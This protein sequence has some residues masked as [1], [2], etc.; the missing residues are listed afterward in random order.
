MCSQKLILQATPIILLLSFFSISGSSTSGQ[1]E[2]TWSTTPNSTDWFDPL[3]WDNGAPNAAG[4]TANVSGAANTVTLDLNTQATLGHLNFLGTGSTKLL[5]TGPLLFDNPGALPASIRTVAA[6]PE[7]LDVEISAP[8]LIAHGEHLLLDLVTRKNLE[9]SGSIDSVDG[10]ITK[11]GAGSLTLSGDNST[12]RGSLTVDAGELVI[13]D[14]NA[15]A[16]SRDVLI[17]PDSRL[18]FVPQDATGQRDADYVIPSVSIDGGIL[19]TKLTTFDARDEVRGNIAATKIDTN[20]ELISDSSIQLTSFDI[21][22][23]DGTISG[24]GGLRFEKR[25][26]PG[27]IGGSSSFPLLSINGSTSY[28]GETVIGPDMRVVF[29]Q[30]AAL[31]DASSGTLVD[32]GTLELHAGG[33][34]EQIEIRRGRLALIEA[35]DP[36]GHKIFLDQGQLFGGDNDGLAATLNT[37]VN[38]SGGAALGTSSGGDNLVLAEGISGT[39]SVFSLNQVEIAGELSA[40]GHFIATNRGPARL[41]GKLSQAGDVFVSDTQLILSG[42]LESPRG[43]F[44]LNPDFTVASVVAEYSNTLE[45][46]VIDPRSA[47]RVG[48][49]EEFRLAVE[50]G[51]ALEIT[52]ELHFFGGTLNGAIT[53]QSVLTKKDRTPGVLE[54]IRGSEFTRVDVEAGQLSVRGDA[55][56]S[57]PEIHLGT[58]DTSRLVVDDAGTYRGDIFLNN[59][60]SNT[61]QAALVVSGNTIL[62]GNIYLGDRGS[63]LSTILSSGEVAE[64]TGVVHGGDFAVLGRQEIRLRSGNH[65]FSGK[66]HVNAESFTL[67]DGGVLNSTSAIVGA[68]RIGLGGGRAGLILDNGGESSHGDR[69]PDLTPVHLEGMK[70]TLIGRT[71][72]QLTE[73]LGSVHATRGMSEIVVTGPSGTG[74]QIQSFNRQPGAGVR[75]D[76]GQAG[77]K[78]KF[79]N[80]P[81][82]DDGIIGGWAVV[83]GY[84]FTDDQDFATYGPNGV[85]AFSDLHTYATN[86]VAATPS[87]NVDLLG[88]QVTLASDQ[89][90]NALRI[91]DSDV[92]LN[93]NKLTLESGGLILRRFGDVIGGGEL[94]AGTTANG[95]LIVSGIGTIEADIVD[96]AQGPVGLTYASDSGALLLSGNNTYSGP[97]VF[98]A[99]TG[100]TVEL[101]REAALPSGTD[102]KISGTDLRI[103]FDSANPLVLGRLEVI[104]NGLIRPTT[105]NPPDLQATSIHIESGELSGFDI[106]GDVPI[107]KTTHG[108]AFLGGTLA[109]HTGSIEIEQG[110]LVVDAL[111]P[112][113]LDDEHAITVRRGGSLR[114]NSDFMIADRKLRLDGGILDIELRGGISAPIEILAGGG[115]I[116]DER[117]T[118]VITSTIT[119]QGPLVVEGGLGNGLIS[120]EADLNT[121]EGPLRF[122]GGTTI[123]RGSN[124]NY[125]QPIEVAASRFTVS[126]TNVLGTSE[127]TILP[128]GRL[129]VTNSVTGNLV[130]A[131]GV[132]GMA[133]DNFLSGD[134]SITN[135]SYI[136]ISPLFDGRR[137]SPVID[138]TLHLS[139]QTN[140]SISPDIAFQPDAVAANVFSSQVQ[141]QI[142]LIGDIVVNGEASITSFDAAVLMLGTIRPGTEQASLNLIGN[143]TFDFPGSIHLEEAKSLAVTIDSEVIPLAFTDSR[144]SLT[145]RGT[146]IGDIA[147]RGGASISPGDSSGVLTIVGDTTIGAGANYEWEIASIIGTPGEAWDLLQVEGNLHFT[148][149]SLTP[150]KLEISDLPG[151]SP[152]LVQPWLIASADSITG[153]DSTAVQFDITGI[154]DVWP[155]LTTDDFVL[156]TKSGNLFLQAIPEPTSSLLASVGILV[157]A[158]LRR[159]KHL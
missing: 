152:G 71:G 77:G 28:S 37:T 29:E 65:T 72:E 89:N 46:V 69:I 106:V 33:G 115:V 43:T 95:E 3:N 91:R 125:S 132:L 142:T 78:V 62:A 159:W 5:G 42:D 154:T 50:D 151:F 140:L 16:S 79:T 148:A 104:D 36:Y 134:L 61:Q 35:L 87:D 131:G 38:Y 31:G 93:G 68:G 52:K 30:S 8:V 137:L 76:L 21:V 39:G 15:L 156:Y 9:V 19:Q 99:G 1:T 107:T 11:I 116:R 83:R 17:G 45:S 153:F 144:S 138:S 49:H 111:G 22:F 53:G 141:E 80:V 146:F 90:I 67:V 6:Q 57:P 101:L 10:D 84:G 26:T 120:F 119:G 51:A 139:D 40:R 150:W 66:T 55:G 157:V 75:F 97:T 94:T 4:D 126:G 12:W 24:T 102:L 58:H 127:V 92:D 88:Q 136:F 113:A 23:I 14:V 145:G 129:N 124:P 85:V 44:F 47:Q 149:T 13:A 130:L 25:A 98:S 34:S 82:L 70:L 86:L 41:S 100:S 143:D 18:I 155:S 110:R 158:N 7:T 103:A 27:V 109:N 118:T 112:A 81:T 32:R 54:D 63:S 135:D 128:E 105:S 48:F 133:P 64:I 147:V 121:F 74:F 122:T 20:L 56:G 73:T 60:R 123:M 2:S 114:T 108:S 96:N 117:G 59:A